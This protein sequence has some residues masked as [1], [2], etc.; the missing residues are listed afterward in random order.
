MEGKHTQGE[1]IATKSRQ[2]AEI[3]V[4]EGQQNVIE[5]GGRAI[6]I[7]GDTNSEA[8][9][10]LIAAAPELLNSLKECLEGVNEL[11]GEYQEGWDNV[12]ETAQQAIKKATS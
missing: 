6:V 8:N 7:I 12:I 3:T 5:C 9:A 1:W 2:S 11:N 4:I 10:K